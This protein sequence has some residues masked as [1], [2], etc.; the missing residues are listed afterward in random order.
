MNRA[1]IRQ[2]KYVGGN[3]GQPGNNYTKYYCEEHAPSQARPIEQRQSTKESTMNREAQIL[4]ALAKATPEEQAALVRG[5]RCAAC[6][7]VSPASDGRRDRSRR[8]SGTRSPHAC[9]D[10]LA[11]HRC[12]GLDRDETP[13]EVDPS[14]MTN[15]MR[16]EA[17]LWFRR[18]SDDVKADREEFGIQAQGKA[19]SV[20]GQFGMHSPEA[21]QVFMDH[22]GH[23]TRKPIGSARFVADAA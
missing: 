16:T 13:V 23:L 15:T 2:R 22:V 3:M 10:V 1:G 19:R 18:V 7:A 21:A 8:S 11:S 17:T 4:A 6:F 20:A 12:D 9:G 5:T 14:E